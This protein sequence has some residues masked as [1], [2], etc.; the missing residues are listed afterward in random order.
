QSVQQAVTNLALTAQP[1]PSASGQ[2]VTIGVAITSA[3]SQP[4]AGSVT[5]KEGSTIIAGPVALDAS[6]TASFVT[7]AL[8]G[9]V[10]TIHAEYSGSANFKSSS[11]DIQ[12]RV[13]RP[14]TVSAGAT[15]SVPEGG[16][17]VL[18]AT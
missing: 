2:P 11:A 15:Y 6:G 1:N 18:T 8:S 5:L 9:G 3:A 7:A 4:V 13:N 16:S 17:V 14:P 12:V 10:H